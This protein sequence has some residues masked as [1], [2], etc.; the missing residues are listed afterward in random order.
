MN[1]SMNMNTSFTLQHPHLG[2]PLRCCNCGRVCKPEVYTT[3]RTGGTIYVVWSSITAAI[4]PGTAHHHVI[5]RTSFAYQVIEDDDD[6][7]WLGP[8]AA[9]AALDDAASH[10]SDDS[11]AESYFAN[12]YPDEDEVT[13][14]GVGFGWQGHVA[15]LRKCWQSRAG[16]V[17]RMLW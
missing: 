11:N 16:D 6:A 3:C 17:L 14:V 4:T 9:G 2:G 13:G 12:S 8:G 5:P 7:A 10:D 1:M 15:F